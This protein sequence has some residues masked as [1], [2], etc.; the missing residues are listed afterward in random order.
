VRGYHYVRP[1]RRRDGTLVH[2]HMRRNPSPRIGAASVLLFVVVLAI[3][4]GLAHGHT[5]GTGVRAHVESTVQQPV[6]LPAKTP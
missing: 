1:Y 5:S 6:K 2:G 4:G 3:L